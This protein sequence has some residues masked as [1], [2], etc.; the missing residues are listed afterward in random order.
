MNRNNYA[1]LRLISVY[2]IIFNIQVT[3]KKIKKK[4]G[5]NK[6]RFETSLIRKNERMRKIIEMFHVHNH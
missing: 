6:A 5:I 2:L 1:C 3:F 4:K